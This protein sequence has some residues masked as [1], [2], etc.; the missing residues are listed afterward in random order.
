MSSLPSRLFIR[1][2]KA[3]RNSP[4]APSLNS[5]AAACMPRSTSAPSPPMTDR[6]A[7]TS[8]SARS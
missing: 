1:S 6:L 7:S 4:A 8:F 3:S 2:C 5:R